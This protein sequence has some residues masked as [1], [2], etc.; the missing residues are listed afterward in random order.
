MV[1]R[2]TATNTDLGSLRKGVG[3][4]V[5]NCSA[6]DPPPLHPIRPRHSPGTLQTVRPPPSP[7]SSPTPG[8]TLITRRIREDATLQQ[9]KCRAHRRTS[10]RISLSTSM[11][12]RR[13]THDALQ[14]R[15]V[16]TGTVRGGKLVCQLPWPPTPAGPAAHAA[17]SRKGARPRTGP[18][19]GP[20]HRPPFP[21]RQAP[22]TPQPP[23]PEAYQGQPTLSKNGNPASRP[24][25]HRPFNPACLEDQ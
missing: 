6:M 7:L 2:T 3:A 8:N 17:F 9:L 25:L 15:F 10:R 4:H 14:V 1:D 12:K 13:W 21:L 23:T 19:G 18:R 11:V 5:G 24:I 20:H 22:V 16:H